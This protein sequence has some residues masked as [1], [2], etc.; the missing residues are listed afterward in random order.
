MG[1]TQYLK[2]QPTIDDEQWDK[3]QDCASALFLQAVKDGVTLCNAFGHKDTGPIIAADCI[4]FNGLLDESHETC[5]IGRKAKDLN[6]CKTAQ[7]P[8]DKYV[9]ALFTI[10]A[11]I[12]GAHFDSDGGISETREGNVLAFEILENK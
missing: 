6:F 5:W 10:V 3:I 4:V 8:Y 7:K 2:D 9:V 12:T 1:Y 11:I